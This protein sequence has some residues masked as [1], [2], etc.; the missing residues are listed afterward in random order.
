VTIVLYDWLGRVARVVCS[1]DQSIGKQEV[2]IAPRDLPKGKYLL[3]IATK[4]TI[5]AHKIIFE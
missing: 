2:I 4:G 3:Q 1:E 5:F